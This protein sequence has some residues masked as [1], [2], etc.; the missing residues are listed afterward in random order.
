V[1]PHLPRPAFLLSLV[2]AAALAVALTSPGQHTVAGLVVLTGLVG[3]TALRHRHR[4]P[5]VVN[6]APPA[7]V[8]AAAPAA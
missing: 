7:D 8:P 5:V 1:H 6:A 2:Y 3:R 4:A